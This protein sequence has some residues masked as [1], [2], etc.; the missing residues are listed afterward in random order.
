MLGE[1]CLWPQN[2]GDVCERSLTTVFLKSRLWGIGA[3]KRQ[4][5]H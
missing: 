3:L 5:L 1:M 4:E 2:Q